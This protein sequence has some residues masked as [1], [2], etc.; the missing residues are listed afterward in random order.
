MRKEYEEKYHEI[1]ETNWWF[2]ARR[3]IIVKMLRNES[4]ELKVLDIG[5]SS[6]LL[7][8]D[9]NKTG[10]PNVRGI[11][12]SKDAVNLSKSIKIN[13]VTHSDAQKTKFRNQEFDIIIAS[14]ILEHLDDDKKALKEWCRILKKDGT[15]IVFTPAFK[16]LWSSHDAANQHKTRYTLSGLNKLLQEA[17]FKV[18]SSS[19][20]NF[21]LFFPAAIIRIPQKIFH[22]NNQSKD[23]AY[24]LNRI[25]N[26][27]LKMLLKV[28]NSLILLGIRFPFGVSVFSL[29]RKI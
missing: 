1:E 10:F 17:G 13:S 19:Y 15:L 9:L 21:L 23:Q 7:I 4:K 27:L 16:F 26:S 5:C 2:V 8:R 28:E 11:D 18:I 12:I 3:D 14:D 24:R 25:I 22:L 6:G 29:A 20:W